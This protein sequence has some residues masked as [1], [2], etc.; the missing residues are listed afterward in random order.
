MRFMTLFLGRRMMSWFEGC[1]LGLDQPGFGICTLSSPNFFHPKKTSW[2]WHSR[3]IQTFSPNWICCSSIVPQFVASF[4]VNHLPW[5]DNTTTHQAW[6]GRSAWLGVISKTF[7]DAMLLARHI[8]EPLAKILQ[9][10]GPNHW[11]LQLW[12]VALMSLDVNN[13]QS[14]CAFEL[15]QNITIQ[16]SW[17]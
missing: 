4:W 15:I 9:K 14:L 12:L 6:T 16:A 5:T 10:G 1:C 3:P 7:L 8:W 13:I 11:L 17:N 2:L